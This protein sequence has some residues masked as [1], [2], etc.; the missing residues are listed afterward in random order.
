MTCLW[1]VLFSSVSLTGETLPLLGLR[2]LFWCT[3][4]FWGD[5]SLQWRRSRFPKH[6]DHR[7][8]LF[9]SYRPYGS[10][11]QNMAGVVHTANKFH[12]FGKL[13]TSAFSWSYPGYLF[14]WANFEEWAFYEIYGIFKLMVCLSAFW[15]MQCIMSRRNE[16]CLRAFS[17]FL[18]EA[19]KISWPFYGGTDFVFLPSA[20]HKMPHWSWF[21]CWI[22]FKLPI[23]SANTYHSHTKKISR[24]CY[25]THHWWVTNQLYLNNLLLPLPFPVMF[26]V[27]SQLATLLSKERP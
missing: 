22:F 13:W 6:Q 14:L 21:P 2:F 17:P 19:T 16:E 11:T 12:I 26:T 1:W 24:H 7:K 27:Q 15:Q 20:T 10:V 8:I 9:S 5:W 25:N 18:S 23:I 3:L 4:L